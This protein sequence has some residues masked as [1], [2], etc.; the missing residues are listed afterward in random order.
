MFVAGS[1]HR[2]RV[3]L[4]MMLGASFNDCF[5]SFKIR[6]FIEVFEFK[7]LLLY[8]SGNYQIHEF[9]WLKRILTAV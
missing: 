3:V 6:V 5:P 7:K 9:D 4:I 2:R 8:G 1:C